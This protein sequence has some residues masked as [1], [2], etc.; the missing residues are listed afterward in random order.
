M[1][2]FSSAIIFLTVFI[3][4]K[5]LGASSKK[6]AHKN[7]E[8]IIVLRM[9]KAYGIVGYIGILI[10]LVIGVIATLGTIK[11]ISDLIMAMSMFL[12]FFIISSMLVMVSKNQRVE[13]GDEKIIAY[14][15]TGKATV[16]KWS[17]VTKVQFSKTSLE[18]K[19]TA[20]RQQ[21]KLHMHFI[22]F[23]DFVDLMKRKLDILVYKDAILILD[24]VKKRF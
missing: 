6:Q 3:L 18:L 20:K 9:N 21:A 13:A 24:T 10:S 7:E 22:G 2:I 12:F 1:K 8:G 4:M 5:Y 19:L 11:N 23:W 17:E 14:S 16:I 15:M